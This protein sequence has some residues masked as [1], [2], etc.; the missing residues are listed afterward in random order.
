MNNPKITQ[1]Q[2]E[3]LTKIHH[4]TINQKLYDTENDQH[5]LRNIIPLT[6][7]KLV[8]REGRDLYRT[9][10]K[11][12]AYLNHNPT[13]PHKT[14]Y[15][16]TTEDILEHLNEFPYDTVRDICKRWNAHYEQA[17][18]AVR[19][20]TKK[21]IIKRHGKTNYA[22]YTLNSPRYPTTNLTIDQQKVFMTIRQ[23][24]PITTTQIANHLNQTNQNVKNALRTLKNKNLI[25]E[26][27]H[28]PN[29]RD[30]QWTTPN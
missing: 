23:H 1:A 10:L 3:I 30:T 13:Y 11:A 18:A 27:D 8:K 12:A 2:Y 22:M 9:T 16:I 28:Q 20:L 26:H 5:E 21:Q 6:K 29:K 17:R 4:A 24:N 7:R 19:R 25:T 14:H 15:Q